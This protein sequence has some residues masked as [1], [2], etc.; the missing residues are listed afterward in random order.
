MTSA[1]AATRISI[2]I[3]GEPGTGKSLLARLI[4][5]LGPNPH[6]P[7]VTVDSLA[8]AD[9]LPSGV[10]PH[11]PGP[12]GGDDP[13]LWA[14]KLAEGR[15]GT[16]FLDEVAALPLELQFHLFHELLLRDNRSGAGH[17]LPEAGG[18]S[19]RQPVITCP[20]WSRGVGF[21]RNFITVSA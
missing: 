2:L 13:R 20:P 3:V 12:A 4:H 8:I 17:H 18:G 16:L 6:R 9:E 10:S 14:D 19:S 1:V 21:A 5:L 7:F 15:G 11:T